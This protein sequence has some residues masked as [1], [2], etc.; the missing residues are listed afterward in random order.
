VRAWSPGAAASW[1]LL[2]DG[3]GDDH[4][5]GKGQE[6]SY[7]WGLNVQLMV[8]YQIVALLPSCALSKLSWQLVSTQVYKGTMGTIVAFLENF[9]L[10]A[11]AVCN[12][13]CKYL[14]LA[15]QSFPL[16]LNG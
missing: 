1:A 10:H 3:D 8:R 16:R 14:L 2:D 4:A 15:I 6:G 11:S 5:D 13:Y 9:A 12:I 7:S